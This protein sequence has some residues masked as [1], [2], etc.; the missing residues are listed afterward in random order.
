[1]R[2][3]THHRPELGPRQLLALTRDVRRRE[4]SADLADLV[5]AVKV[6]IARGGW[7]YPRPDQL[8]QALTWVLDEA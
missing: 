6:R 5:E 1:M 8:T 4:S 7:A 3:P 2:T